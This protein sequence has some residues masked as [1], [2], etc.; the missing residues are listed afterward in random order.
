[1]DENIPP[2]LCSHL[3]SIGHPARHVIKIGLKQT[4]D[5]AIFE[6][7]EE[8]GETIITHDV[9]FGA[10]HAFSGKSKPSII[11]FR[12][13]KINTD[14][15]FNLLEKYLPEL[16]QDLVSGAF[17]SIDEF[18]IRVRKLPIK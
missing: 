9:G 7:A 3:E 15:I 8:S 18:S 6:F 4:A 17:V 14:I 12:H 1:M 5:T 16:E 11:L 10:I 13:Q 2:S